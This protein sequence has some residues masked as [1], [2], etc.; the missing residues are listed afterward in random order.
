[1]REGPRRLIAVLAMALVAVVGVVAWWP[2]GV[3]DAA[4]PLP[5]A[6]SSVT[7]S[8][9]PTK[10]ASPQPRSS[11]VASPS[12]TPSRSPAPLPTPVATTSP[13]PS[14]TS[15]PAAN[16]GPAGQ[17]CATP[18]SS[19]VPTRYTIERLGVHERVFAMPTTRG[20]QVPAPPKNDR[21]SAGWWS[22]GPKPGAGRGK[23]VMTIHTYRPSLRPALGNE[24]FRGGQSA[25][26]PGDIIK[27]HGSAG[28]VACYRFTGA[29][30][31]W[32]RDY[33]PASKL[34]LDPSGA[35][36]LVIV[37]CW[38]FNGQTGD[39]DSRVM[40]QFEQV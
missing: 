19:F 27:L 28:Q 24:L 6:A 34:M 21:R 31:V 2:R 20:G 33:D 36:S 8:P 17:A 37:I 9:S 40:F 23:A 13:A 25:L 4:E 12:P 30:K 5:A 16:A 39:W 26:R 35:P 7:S 14:P 18:S 38:D 15:A 22:D 10:R 29:P 32:V 1:M 3:P 11:P